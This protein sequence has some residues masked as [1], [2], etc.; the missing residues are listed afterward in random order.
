MSQRAAFFFGDPHITTIDGVLYSFNGLGEYYMVYSPTLF[1]LQARTQKALKDDG[2]PSDA[3]VFVAFAAKDYNASG[4][5]TVSEKT[6]FDAH[7]ANEW[8]QTAVFYYLGVL[9]I[10][11]CFMYSKYS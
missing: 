5:G 7:A 10:N 11:Q 4:S 2:T 3:T 1:T 9:T 6:L 8:I